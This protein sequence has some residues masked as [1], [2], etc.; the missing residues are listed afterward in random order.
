MRKRRGVAVKLKLTGEGR[1]D[2]G[3]LGKYDWS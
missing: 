3:R 1:S 2:S